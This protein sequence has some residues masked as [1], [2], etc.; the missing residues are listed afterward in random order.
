[1]RG[2]PPED[3]EMT[4]PYIHRILWLSEAQNVTSRSQRLPTIVNIYE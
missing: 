3:G 2:E 4:L 1:M